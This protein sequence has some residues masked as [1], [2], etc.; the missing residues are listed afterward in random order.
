MENRLITKNT[1]FVNTIHQ[2]V[3]TVIGLLWPTGNLT[4]LLF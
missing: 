2:A 1:T 4:Q 3:H